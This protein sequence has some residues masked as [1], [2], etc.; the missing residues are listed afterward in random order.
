MQTTDYPQANIPTAVLRRAGSILLVDDEPALRTVG[1]AILS[2]MNLSIFTASSGED[3]ITAL[4]TGQAQGCLPDIVIL[5]LT[6]PGG[7][8]GLDTFDQIQDNFPTIPVIACSGFFGDGAEDVCQRLGFA[9]SLP[10]PYTPDGLVAVVR[11]VLMKLHG[12]G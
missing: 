9:D 6:M 11:R 12:E 7:I 3:C 10:K 5:D 2:T 4:Q 8:S 1:K